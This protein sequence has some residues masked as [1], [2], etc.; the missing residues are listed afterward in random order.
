MEDEH[1]ALFIGYL[2]GEKI[3]AK[4]GKLPSVQCPNYIEVEHFSD[5]YYD[6]VFVDARI[7]GNNSAKIY[8]DKLKNA[9]M[10]SILTSS[11]VIYGDF[12]TGLNKIYYTLKGSWPNITKHSRQISTSKYDFDGLPDKRAWEFEFDVDDGDANYESIIGFSTIDPESIDGEKGEKANRY[13]VGTKT[14]DDLELY[15]LD[16]YSG[17]RIRITPYANNLHPEIEP[18]FDQSM[19]EGEVLRVPIDATD[20][21]SNILKLST[22]D[23]LPAFATMPDEYIIGTGT[24]IVFEPKDTDVG[25]YEDIT[26]IVEDEGGLTAEESFDLEVINLNNPPTLNPIEDKTIFETNELSFIVSATDPDKDPLTY[27]AQ[28][29]PEGA[30][31]SNKEFTWTPTYDQAGA[32]AVTFSVSDGELTDDEVIIITVQNKNRLPQVTMDPISPNPA[33]VGQTVKFKAAI[34]D[35]DGEGDISYLM[36]RFGDGVSATGGIDYKTRTHTYK[37]PGTFT[38]T[39]ETKDKSGGPVIKK[40]ETITVK[41]INRLR[42]FPKIPPTID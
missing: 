1:R 42:K 15:M 8:I 39:L 29:L 41:D 33:L 19:E 16:V 27:S 20:E 31:F 23:P 6:N 30:S 25:I 22:L 5:N 12:S 3:L 34:T 7:H 36:W 21:N 32:Y 4:N 11:H 13:Y 28:N 10:N 38:V 18:I 37:E 26:V 9:Q 35:P 24:D 14:D 40:T 17:N 2:W